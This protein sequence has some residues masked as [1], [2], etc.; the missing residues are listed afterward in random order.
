MDEESLQDRY[1]NLVSLIRQ[2]YDSIPGKKKFVFEPEDMLEV[3]LEF[4][5]G[6][7]DLREEV[8]DLNRELVEKEDEIY[9]LENQIDD[10]QDKISRLED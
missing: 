10:L 4:I 1:N 3:T 9:D 8:K 7:D 2:L 6:Y 5:E